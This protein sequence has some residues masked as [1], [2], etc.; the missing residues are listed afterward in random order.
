MKLIKVR[1]KNYRSVEELAFEIKPLD[2]R[3]FTYGLIGVN[4]AGKST[5]LKALALKDKLKNERGEPLPHLKDFKNP[6]DPIEIIYDYELDSVEVKECKDYLAKEKETIILDGVTFSSI[7]LDIVFNPESPNEPL[8]ILSISDL[9]ETESREEI[10]LALT[11]HILNK[12]HKSIFWT[13]EDRYL[14]SQPIN[15]STFASDPDIISIPLRNCFALAGINGQAEIARKISMI[16]DSTEREYLEDILGEKVTEHI[17]TA[18]PMHRIKITFDI[19]DGLINFHIHDLEAK[20]RAKTA[21]QRSDGFKQFISFL[22]TI[23]A[24]NKSNVLRQSIL[25]LDEPETHLHPQAQEDL[26]K[27][28]TDITNNDRDNIV[29]FATHSNYMID[30]DDLSRNYRI[31]KIGGKTEKIQLDKKNSTYASVTYEAFEISSTDYHNQLYDT[32]REKYASNINKD[33]DGVSILEFDR[34]LIQD[35]KLKASFPFKNKD[36]W[37]ALPTYVR[38]AIHYPAN[39]DKNFDKHLKESIDLMRSYEE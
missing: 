5:I 22:L 7:Q 11:E 13:A 37:V 10:E 1:I 21:D 33:L 26:L 12:M 30:K 27:E 2:D 18:W 19:S 6:L 17:Q 23:S 34:F 20:E 25:L 3:T 16:S 28:L 35:K 8:P 14:L 32:L 36:N 9:S 15:L 39:K 24:E 4:E 31:T 29:F 38:N